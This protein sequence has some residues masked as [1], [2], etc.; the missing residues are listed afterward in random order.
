MPRGRRSEPGRNGVVRS[1]ALNVRNKNS[2]RKQIED[3]KRAMGRADIVSLSEVHRGSALIRWAKRN[4]YGVYVAKGKGADSA[5]VW[6]KSRVTL[7]GK[8]ESLSL[9]D[10]EG[11]RGGARERFAAYGLFRD[12]ETGN[13]F[14]QIA[15]HTVNLH[16]GSRRLNDRIM[17]EQYATL[18]RLS[19]RLSK[20]A[21]VLL[22]GDL[23]YRHPEIAGLHSDRSGKGIMHVMAGDGLDPQRT[24]AIGGFNSDHLFVFS[25]LNF[26]AGPSDPRPP[27]GPD[28]PEPTTPTPA[29][30]F[31]KLPD[32]GKPPK[33]RGFW[34]GDMGGGPSQVAP[35]A[36]PKNEPPRWEPPAP[37]PLEH[38]DL[39]WGSLD[40]IPRQFDVNTAVEMVSKSSSGYFLESDW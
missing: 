39:D 10:L 30:G 23:N 36:P 2:P 20:S 31:D 6:D 33:F 18:S 26:K 11:P 35:G 17:N 3:L 5:I 22:A 29:P 28:A 19:R 14:W 1:G 25:V 32:V 16:R 40:F 12:R 4:G 27:A 8:P 24:R 38:V 34:G 37:A 7:V 13:Q 21:P 9:N 15:A